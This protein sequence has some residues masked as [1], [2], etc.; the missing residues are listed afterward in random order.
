[1]EAFGWR[2]RVNRVSCSTRDSREWQ[3]TCEFITRVSGN[4]R[5]SAT[6]A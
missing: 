3:H 1:M 5:V 6:L 4:K 2:R